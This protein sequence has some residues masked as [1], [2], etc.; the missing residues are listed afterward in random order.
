MSYS[1]LG[2]NKN[3]E[4]H[5]Y[6]NNLH[7]ARCTHEGVKQADQ[8]H[9]PMLPCNFVPVQSKA[10]SGKPLYDITKTAST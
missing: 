9:I 1:F 10:F 6:S 2:M 4:M 5:N 7:K 8:W 3:Q